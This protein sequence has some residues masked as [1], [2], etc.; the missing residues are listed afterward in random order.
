VSNNCCKS[1]DVSQSKVC[2]RILPVVVKYGN[3]ETK[4]FALLD[5]GSDVTLCSDSLVKR[6]GAKG[7]P[8]EFTITT[9]NQTTQ[10]RRGVELNLQVSAVGGNDVI[11]LRRVWSVEK[12][13]ISL[14]SCPTNAD[15]GKWRHLEGIIIPEISSAQVEMLIGSDT[16]EAFWVEEQRRGNRGEP[17]AIRSVLGWTIVGPTGKGLKANRSV[18]FQ[19]TGMLD[20]QLERMWNTDFPDSCTDT[21]T[22]M[23]VEDK[24]A[25]S[26]MVSTKEREGDN[27]KLGLPWRDNQV[28]L[29][30]NRALA[31]TRLGHLRRKLLNTDELCSL[32]RE[33]ME[34]Y[35]Q[36]GY[37]QPI[38]D[39]KVCEPGKVWYLPHHPVCSP[40]KPGKVRIVFDCAAKYRGTSLNDNLLQ[41]PD[42][43]NSLVGVLVRFRE[44]PVALVADIEAM[45]H[46]VKVR[47]IDRDALRFLWWSDGNMDC[48]PTEYC[49]TVH[50]FGATSSPSCAA[51]SLQCMASDNAANFSNEAVRT[52]ERNFYVDDLLKSV[53]DVETGVCLSSELREL[54]SKGGFR[55]TKWISNSEEV[56]G[57]FPE[58]EKS[59]KCTKIDFENDNQYERTLGLQWYVEKDQFV[60]DVDLPDKC[61]T[62]R[63]IL[64]V[65]SSLFDPLGLVAP[66]TLIP[67]LILQDACR[68][69][70]QWDEKLSDLDIEKWSRWLDSL[71]TMSKVSIDRCFQPHDI[72]DSSKRIELHMFSDASEFAYAAAVYIRIYDEK[73]NSKC[74]LVIGK[75]RLAPIKS[76]SIPRLELAAAVVAVKLYQLVSQELDLNVD[77]RYFWTD[78]MI[79]LGY[80][81]N[82]TRR[83]KTFVANRLAVI[84]DVTL[85]TD[86]RYVPSEIN[87]ADIGS[88]GVNPHE[89]DKIQNWLNGPDFLQNCLSDWPKTGRPVVIPAD[90]VECKQVCSTHATNVKPAT[91]IDN[92]L[93]RYSDWYK[94]QRAVAWLLRFKRYL[95]EKYKQRKEAVSC[96]A[97][98]LT[99]R[100]I[101]EATNAIIVSVQRSEYSKYLSCVLKLG[102]VPE[103]SSLAKLSPYCTDDADVHNDVKHQ[104]VLPR[105]HPATRI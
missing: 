57:T 55:L 16:P 104:I 46:Q 59:G 17:Y 78:S 79:V 52:V 29:P 31:V 73:G 13:P 76:M 26:T 25:L 62:R 101:R 77:A 75:S 50:L 1:N 14:E 47:D 103:Q 88:R 72:D 18:H 43:I 92:L 4:T 98:H 24:R 96:S 80:I 66:V 56:M 19:Q 3:R 85:Q 27:Y 86:W 63:G 71:P 105:K 69:K 20:V 28:N 93:I 40:H 5:E 70:L 58:S 84:H 15:V 95:I 54:L 51:Y 21:R 91:G 33:T 42:L 97:K 37:A 44:Q 36:K 61:H 102:T 6:L 53:R 74:S 65:A 89:T 9:V 68:K 87:P 90:D 49:M 11:D 83:F 99:V 34:M 32:Y 64:S 23:S 2:L 35:I 60:F 94:L 22:G 39:E 30:N 81:R 8:R 67:K 10:R 82:E 45:F 41:G 7:N 100:E 48:P 38:D 12:L